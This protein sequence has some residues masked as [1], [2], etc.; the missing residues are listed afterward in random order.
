MLLIAIYKFYELRF[1]TDFFTQSCAWNHPFSLGRQRNK[2][3]YQ[4]PTIWGYYPTHLANSHPSKFE[5]T[6][7]RQPNAKNFIPIATILSILVYP[8]AYNNS[9]FFFPQL[10]SSG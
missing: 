2:L 3:T 9:F 6:I 10:Y 7:I 1:I 8:V 5:P 4:L